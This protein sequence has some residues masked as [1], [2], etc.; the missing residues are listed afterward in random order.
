MSGSTTAT[1]APPSTPATRR[2][3]FVGGSSAKFW[4]VTVAGTSVTVRYGRLGTDGQ[5]QTKEFPSAA[6]ASGNAERLIAQKAA[7]GYQEVSAV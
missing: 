1:P 7:K 6:A 5:T 4:Q 2:F 3:E